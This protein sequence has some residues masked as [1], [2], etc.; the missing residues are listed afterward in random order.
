M[1][2]GHIW[3]FVIAV[4]SNWIALAGGAIG[5]AIGL[6]EK[7]HNKPFIGR[8][9]WL[10]MA[11][12]FLIACFWAWSD[13]R[14][15]I[16]K[17]HLDKI[18]LTPREL[19]QVYNDRTSDQGEKVAAAYIG[20][21]MEVS[22]TIF[23]VRFFPNGLFRKRAGVTLRSTDNPTV[24]PT[25]VEKWSEPLSVLRPGERIRAVGQIRRIDAY[26][27]WLEEC[28]LIEVIKQTPLPSPS[29]THEALPSPS[30]TA[31]PTLAPPATPKKKSAR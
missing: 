22:G 13:E 4:I 14:R 8:P 6:W 10:A 17:L 19:V 20:K 29:P 3:D 28:E 30:Q 9:F 18:S 2:L 16:E 26:S 27:V 11:A 25:F 1:L 12:T 31:Q 15:Q 24:Y 7:F 5:T 21:W 23:D